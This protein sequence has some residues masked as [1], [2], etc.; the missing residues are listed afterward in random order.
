MPDMRYFHAKEKFIDYAYD[1]FKGFYPDKAL[2][3]S[4][5]E[6]IPSDEAKNHFLHIASF[7][8]F[9]VRDAK[10]ICTDPNFPEYTDYIDETYR[11]IAMLSLIEA[12]YTTDEWQDFY[13]WLMRKMK[14]GG[15][16]ITDAQELQRLFEEYNKEHGATQKA[17]RFF[18]NLPESAQRPI[19]EGLRAGKD[20]KSI[21][22]LAKVLYRIR[23]KFLHEAKLIVELGETAVYQGEKNKLVVTTLT[24]TQ[25]QSIFEIG[26]LQHFGFAPPG[27]LG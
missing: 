4:Q 13:E 9:L 19:L 18:T 20:Q 26:V 24:L 5:F 7:Y 10:V 1:V 2:F 6:A 23:S 17:V 14:A 21:E 15:L 22:D 25:L 12:L 27:G 3:V 16:S 11:Y 8:K